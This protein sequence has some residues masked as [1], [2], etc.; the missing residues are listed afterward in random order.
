MLGHGLAGAETAGNRG[1]AAFCQGKQGVQNPLAGDQRHRGRVPFGHGPG[2]ADGPLLGHSDLFFRPV[3]KLQRQKPLLYG[4]AA[5]G[6]HV[7]H[8]AFQ[9]RRQHDL[10]DNGRR[11]RNLGDDSA[12]EKM[13]ALFHG[14]VGVPALVHVQGVHVDAAADI[15]AG[16]SGDFAQGPFD[17]VKNVVEDAG[18]QRN[19]HRRTGS[20][21]GF[22][23]F[24]AGGFLV[25]LD[26]GVVG[27]EADDLPDQIFVSY[28]YHFV[29]F[30]SHVAFDVDDGTVDAVDFSCLS[31]A[32]RLLSSL[33]D[34]T[35]NFPFPR[36]SGFQRNCP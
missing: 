35:G 25:Y 26:D 22:A 8:V 24:H 7:Q 13:V 31:H 33:P 12:G 4:I 21:H 15:K 6:D 32:C 19:G 36:P 30:Q 34:R 2:N 27:V 10:V 29:H 5:I 16:F 11:F 3:G 1:G 20:G 23:G 14:D 28:I 9:V 18:G 17:A